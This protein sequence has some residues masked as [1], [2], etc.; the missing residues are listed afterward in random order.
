MS[1]TNSVAKKRT[2]EW[3]RPSLRASMKPAAQE[4]MS[5]SELTTVSP[6]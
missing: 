6:W 3:S 5:P 2:T 4:A 1:R